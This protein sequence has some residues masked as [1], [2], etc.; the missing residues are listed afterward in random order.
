VRHMKPVAQRPHAIRSP[1]TI[2][3][4]PTTMIPCVAVL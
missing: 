1:A 4:I 2:T 3:N